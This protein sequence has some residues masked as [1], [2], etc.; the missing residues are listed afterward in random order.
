MWSSSVRSTRH[1]TLRLRIERR[2]RTS[3]TSSGRLP[4]KVEATHQRARERPNHGHDQSPRRGRINHRHASVDCAEYTSRDRVGLARKRRWVEAGGHARLDE[5]WLDGDHPKT[6]R[7]VLVIQALEIVREAGLCCAVK[8][9]GFATSFPGNRAE[10]AQGAATFLQQSLLSPTSQNKTVLEKSIRRSNSARSGSAS[11]SSWLAKIAAVTTT[12]S[13]ATES[14]PSCVDCR[15]EHLGF[16]EITSHRC[17]LSLRRPARRGRPRCARD[18]SLLRPRIQISSPRSAANG[19]ARAPSPWSHPEWQ[20][21]SQSPS[22][23]TDCALRNLRSGSQ[24]SR[25]AV[26][27]SR[28]GLSIASK[29]SRRVNESFAR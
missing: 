12:A 15:T 29:C 19:Q 4:L 13:R 14:F 24:R 8:D 2:D 16:L 10:N 25:I 9:D 23:R 11:S 3:P 7:A 1:S 17:E 21:S 22:K 18:R 5:T 6:V 26:N 20:V 27:S 28:R